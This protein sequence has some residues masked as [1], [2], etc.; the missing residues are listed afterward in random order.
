VAPPLRVEWLGQIGWREAL[1]EQMKRVEARRAGAGPDTLLL[2]EH[3]P[4]VTLGRRFEPVHLRESR[5]AL[6]ARGIPVLE[7]ARGGSVT[8]HGPGQLVGYL[9]IDLAAR[10]AADVHAFLRGIESDLMAAARALGVATRRVAGR[11]GVF[12]DAPGPARK[13]ASIGV[14]LRG[15]VSFHGFALN[16]TLDPAAFAA[17]V[18]CG[19]ADVAMTS[20]ACELGAGAPADLGEQARAAVAGAFAVRWGQP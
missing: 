7:A 10:G 1:E 18:P 15:W 14:G 16:V 20:L 3:P 2:L 17:I 4:V 6:A 12:V 5:E 9:V 11:T 13:L 19:L 8:Y